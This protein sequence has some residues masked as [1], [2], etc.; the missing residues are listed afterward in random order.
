MAVIPSD[1]NGQITF[2]EQHLTP[3]TANA[4]ALNLAPAD[5][6]ALATKTTAA[7][8]A[9]NA[10]LAARQQAKAATE[11]Y[12]NLVGSMTDKAREMVKVIK[13]WADTKNDPGVYVLAQIPAPI[14]PTAGSRTPPGQPTEMRALL[15]TDGSITLTWKSTNAA[16]SSGGSFV[17]ARRFV[18]T[19]TAPNPAFVVVGAAAGSGGSELGGARTISFTDT[20]IPVG[21]GGMTYIVTP[22]RGGK[23]GDASEALTVSFGGGGASFTVGAAPA[24]FT[25]AA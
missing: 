7:R 5:V 10:A 24:G 4:A 2:C 3:W 12:Y 8:A 13:T 18:P 1:R 25:L 15:N 21:V 20:T 11:A 16:S 22:R 14:P 23:N 9:F 6:T 17:I 19:P